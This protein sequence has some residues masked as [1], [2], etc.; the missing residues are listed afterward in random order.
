MDSGETKLRSRALTRR[1]LLTHTALGAGAALVSTGL[2]AACGSPPKVATTTGSSSTTTSSS[3]TAASASGAATTT[4]ASPATGTTTEASPSATEAAANV[5][6]GGILNMGIPDIGTMN[7]FV[8]NTIVENYILMML[9]PACASLDKSSNRVPYV[10]EKWETSPDGMTHTIHLRQ[11][12]MWDDGQPLTAQDV[13]FTAEFEAKNEFSWKASIVSSDNIASM[14]TPDDYTLVVTMAQPFVSFLN[15]FLYWFRIMP[16]HV[17]EP[18][19]DPKTYA[20][21]KPVGAG[22]FK[23]SQWTKSQFIELEARKDYNY[24]PVGRPPYIDKLIYRIYPD[25]NTLVLALQNGTIDAAPYGIPADSVDTVKQNPDLD[26]IHNQSTGY[27]EINFNVAKNKYLADVKV[28]QALAMAVDKKAIVDLVLKGFGGVMT[29]CVSP[30]LKDWYDPSV[31][32]WPFDIDAGKKL[33]ADAGYNDITLRLEYSSSDANSQKIAPILK[34]NWE[35]L[36]VKITLDAQDGNALYDRVR[37]QHDFDMWFSGWGIE[38]D[39]PFT[40]YAN[41]YSGQYQEGSNNMIGLKD[42][43]FDDLILKAYHAKSLDEAKEYVK[44]L[45]AMEHEL[46]PAIIVYYPEFNLAY[47]KKRWDGFQVLPGSLM[48]IAAYQSMVNVHQL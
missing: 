44:Q 48:G 22:P 29:T 9:Y 6:H 24:P 43:A 33:L 25:V 36:G 45:Q 40:Y 12:F 32:D 37:F 42:D 30:V 35:K 20:N 7:P 19:P 13:K 46:L 38:D 31:K 15:E 27:N 1:R 14:E 34:E 8:S 39:P 11:G 5:N 21:D 41:Y 47:N 16:K 23:L 26:V 4:T 3:S 28:R 18:I 10:A 17:W 2:L